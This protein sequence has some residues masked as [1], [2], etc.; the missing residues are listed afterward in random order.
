MKLSHSRGMSLV[1]TFIALAIFVLVIVAMGAFQAGIFSHQR[2]VSG[3][4]QT[5]QDAQIILKTILTELRSA[6]PG[7]NGSYIINSA[8]T[9]SISFFSDTNNDGQT[10]KI[11]YSL[12]GTTLYRSR[13]P[14]SGTPPVYLGANQSTTTLLSNVRNSTS[15][16]IFQY[17]DQFY[18]GTSSALALP[19]DVSTIRLIQV[20]ITLDVDPRI[21]PAPRTYTVQVGLRNLK[22]NL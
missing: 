18:T 11:A 10:D 17:F 6:A 2:V 14:P 22:T 13:I 19:V 12:S 5:A 8:A 9:S 7:A 15:T 16:P 4:L 1:E 3:S 20:S 21:S